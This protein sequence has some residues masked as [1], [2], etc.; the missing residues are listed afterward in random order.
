MFGVT[1]LALIRSP[2]PWR[3]AAICEHHNND[4]AK[5]EAVRGERFAN[6]KE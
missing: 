1:I 2:F 5:Q 4:Y 3:G 6:Q